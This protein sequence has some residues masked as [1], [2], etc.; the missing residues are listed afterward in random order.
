MHCPSC[1]DQTPLDQKFCR[2]C[3]LS[4]ESISQLLAEQVSIDTPSLEKQESNQAVL[5]SMYRWMKWG[6]LVLLIGLVLLVTNKTFVMGRAVQL[7]ASFLLLGGTALAT[8][9]VLAPFRASS[10]KKLR[11][12]NRPELL[13]PKPTNEL[14]DAPI[15][16]PIPSVTERTTELLVSSE[17]EKL[18]E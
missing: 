1:G 8:Y 17:A 18:A 14:P 15:P 4:L 7:L 12:S 11:G 6:F 5:R 10:A 9:G 16:I 2:K 3:G 13:H